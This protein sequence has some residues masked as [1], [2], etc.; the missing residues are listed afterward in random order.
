[1][2]VGESVIVRDSVANTGKDFASAHQLY[3]NVEKALQGKGQLYLEQNEGMEK[4]AQHLLLPKGPYF[5]IYCYRVYFTLPTVINQYLI[6]L[7]TK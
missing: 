3:Q 6:V 4:L 1:M 5:L 7:I 2:P